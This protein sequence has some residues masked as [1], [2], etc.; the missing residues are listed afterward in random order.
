[1]GDPYFWYYYPHWNYYW[2]WRATRDVVRSPGHWT[3]TSYVVVE[4]SLYDNASDQLVGTAK[5]ETMDDTEFERLGD[6][7]VNAVSRRL[8]DAELLG[9]GDAALGAAA[10]RAGVSVAGPG[11]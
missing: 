10:R 11:R 4:T 1:M 8:F 3:E 7:I 6:S 5:S 2:H 9:S